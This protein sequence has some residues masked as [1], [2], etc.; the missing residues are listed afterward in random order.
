MTKEEITEQLVLSEEKWVC[1]WLVCIDGVNKGKS[2][3][4][5]SG[6]NSIGND[7]DMP[8]YIS[9]DMSVEKRTHGVIVY[10]PKKV[11][12]TM[13]NG[14]SRGLVYVEE[15]I[16]LAERDLESHERIQLGKSQFIYVALCNDIFDW[17]KNSK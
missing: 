1:G 14:N 13:L 8:I 4:I 9:G 6:K 2:Y 16:V 3:A 10:D 11:K 5:H 15:E 12:M 17:Y 7:R